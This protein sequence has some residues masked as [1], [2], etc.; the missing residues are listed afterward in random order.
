M[1]RCIDF[2]VAALLI[3]L[4]SPVWLVA[5]LAVK[6]TSRGPVLFS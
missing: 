5:A 3:V 1:K 4:L 2:A 6:L